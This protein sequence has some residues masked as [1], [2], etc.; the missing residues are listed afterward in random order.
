MPETYTTEEMNLLDEI[1]VFGMTLQRLRA[2]G[3]N[4]YIL[5]RLT[6]LYNKITKEQA[7]LLE[8]YSKDLAPEQKKE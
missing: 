1:Q 2:A 8:R 3:E 6:S 5:M 4:P 7:G